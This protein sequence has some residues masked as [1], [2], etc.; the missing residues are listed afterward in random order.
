MD[1]FGFDQGETG[2]GKAG[3]WMSVV[4][5]GGNEC[6]EREYINLCRKHGCHAKVFCKFNNCI[7]CRIGEP[8]LLILFTHTVSHKMVRCA[9]A[10]VDDD[11]Q[12]VRCHTSSI[13]S[14]KNILQEKVSCFNL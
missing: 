11:T 6:M 9:L 7:K 5:I 3:E 1:L 8:D 12:I 2:S 4:I 10:N 13:A 14:L